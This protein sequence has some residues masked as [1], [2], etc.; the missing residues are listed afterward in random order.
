MKYLPG[1]PVPAAGIVTTRAVV[2]IEIFSYA[3]S[4]GGR[5]VT[6]RAVVWIEI[7]TIRGDCR[8]IFGHHPCGG[9]D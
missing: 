6:T 8:K 3:R 9:V 2:W 1:F 4:R 7:G 5:V